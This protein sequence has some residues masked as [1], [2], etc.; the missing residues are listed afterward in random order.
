MPPIRRRGRGRP[1]K[2]PKI[3]H[4]YL[5]SSESQI[6]F[7]TSPSPEISEKNETTDVDVWSAPAGVDVVSIKD[8]PAAPEPSSHSRSENL[9]QDF[10][11]VPRK[12]CLRCA[13]KLVHDP[14]RNCTRPHI[15]AKC[16]YC[17]STHKPCKPVPESFMQELARIQQLGKEAYLSGDLE[18]FQKTASTWVTSVEAYQRITAQQTKRQLGTVALP[19]SSGFDAETLSLLRWIHRS[20]RSIAEMMRE[21]LGLPPFSD[22]EGD[23]PS[24]LYAGE[25]EE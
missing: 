6:L 11:P 13:K 16:R 14:K 3:V 23:V 20:V 2:I 12:M 4:S 25:V 15:N 10:P 5:F 22:D 9:Q 21:S 17:H 8:S 19:T 7:P 18:S 24:G 1:R